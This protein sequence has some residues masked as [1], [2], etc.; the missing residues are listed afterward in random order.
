MVLIEI[1]IEA[2]YLKKKSQTLQRKDGESL[3]DQIHMAFGPITSCFSVE[4][5][6]NRRKDYDMNI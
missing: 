5:N 2:H 1:E 6:I 4:R 3:T